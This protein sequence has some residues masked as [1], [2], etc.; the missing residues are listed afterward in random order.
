VISTTTH[1]AQSAAES[2]GSRRWVTFVHQ[3]G[4]LLCSTLRALDHLGILE[5]SLG[6]ERSIAELYP[7]VRPEGFGYMRVG[8][9]SLA[10][11]G[12]LAE[13]PTLDPETT[14]LRWTDTGRMASRHFSQYLA[15]GRFLCEFED[16]GPDA[17]SRPWDA[18]KVESFLALV[19]LAC[20]RWRVDPRMPAG[21]R[22]LI[23]THLDASLVVP[24]M[25]WL[26]ATGK[27]TAVGP[28]LMDGG[29]GEGI[30]RV[31]SALGWID[32]E[33]HAWTPS[34]REA[35]ELAVHFGMAASYLPLLSRLPAVF[36][37]ELAVAPVPGAPE[38][39]V[40]RPLN[41]GASAAAHTRYF[42]DAD[43]IFLEVFDAEPVEEQP[44]FIADMGCGDGSWLVHLHELMTQRTLR[45]RLAG[46]HPLLMVG[47][48]YNA[49]A[50][51]QA[52]LVLDEAEVPALLLHG[53]VSD[54][55]GLGSTLAEHG[56]T[57]EDGLHIRA[58]IDHDRSYRGADPGTPVCGWSTGAYVDRD[59]RPL[60]A[61]A[62]EQ[63]LV[64]HLG[65]WAPHVRKHGLVMLEA[66]CVAP[67]IARKH[68][69]AT[70]SVAFDAYHGYSHQFPIAHSAFRHCCKAAGLRPAS[71]CER[72]YPANRPFVAVSLNRLLVPADGAALPALDSSAPREDTWQ[73][74]P[75][76]DLEDGRALHQL[77]YAGGDVRFP[78][79]WCS[80][81]TGFVVAGALEVVEARLAAAAEGEVIRVLDYGAGTGLAAIEFLKGCCDRGIDQRLRR[82]GA[83]LE[84]HLVDLPSSWFAQGFELLGECAWT[85]FHSLRG[86]DGG[87]RPLSEVTGAR[88]MDAVM[89]NMVFHLVPPSALDRVATELAAVIRPGGRLIWSS[90]D[91][92]PAG[93]YAVLFHDANRTLRERWLQLLH[94]EGSPD[95]SG[96]ENGDVARGVTPA[97]REAVTRARSGLDAAALREAQSRADR[98]VL[99][100]ANLAED[101]AAALEVRF[102]SS[103]ELATHELLADDV[104]DTLLV[105]SNQQEFLSEIEDRSL[106]EH[107]IEDLLRADVIPALQRGPGGTALGLNVQ[108][109]LGSAV[110]G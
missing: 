62:V 80:A 37:G 43:G 30:A 22:A 79:S 103:V 42:A 28:S 88:T 86:A 31:L 2:V 47:V 8:L 4:V 71:H 39:H 99:P 16:A 51:E 7:G 107:V 49:G 100:R 77:L 82:V 78:R 25:L 12:W 85:R 59:G 98:R 53:D 65:R 40:N 54:P 20:D 105:P 64:A 35:A 63:D 9:R 67:E 109:T 15:A 96:S 56:L 36:R 5:P 57:M 55:D 68:L 60:D 33:S 3:D 13:L 24:S 66:H 73:P 50:L 83:T 58:F 34:G 91:L 92:G 89:A 6:A 18:R 69:G 94:G 44:R 48:D 27:V 41:V 104:V 72:R 11:Q 46:S 32:P 87:F 17:W 75:A 95:G 93:T 14:V 10:S 52:R 110:A 19:A 23:E 90:P 45:G 74:E 102:D 26:R 29:P 38:W 101:V 106:R 81:A 97:V 84:M 70:H 21:L 76:T 1:Q 61:R 108:W